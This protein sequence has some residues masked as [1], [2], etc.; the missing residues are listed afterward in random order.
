MARYNW[1]FNELREI[2]NEISK[3]YE[4]EN[5]KEEKEA[6][7]ETLNGYKRMLHIN[8]KEI[9]KI[10]S[11]SVEDIPIFYDDFIKKVASF[12]EDN[13]PEYIDLLTGTYPLIKKAYNEEMDVNY[14]IAFN[15]DSLIEIVLDFFSKMTPKEFYQKVKNLLEKNKDFLNITYSKNYNYKDNSTL[16]SKEY[17]KKFVLVT[18]HNDLLDFMGLPHEITHYLLNNYNY[19]DYLKTDSKFLTE[20]E[21]CLINLLIS[22]YYKNNSKTLFTDSY[23]KNNK[24][25][26]DSLFFKHKILGDIKEHIEHF[27]IK[28][29][30]LLSLDDDMKLIPERFCKRVKKFNLVDPSYDYLETLS[31]LASNETEELT[32]GFSYIAALDIYT[33]CLDDPEKAF[34]DLRNIK[35]RKRIKNLIPYLRENNIT[36]MDDNYKSLKK[37]IKNMTN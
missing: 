37:Y 26:D 6:L 9:P 16:F 28:N 33:E 14:K 12:Y 11:I 23:D 5:N 24:V 30:F 36:F 25:Y 2:Y 7:L 34:Y 10:E 27:I 17:K 31:Y 3:K 19:S 1:N 21:G 18:R 32:Y 13:K 20:I 35:K 8:R 22:E 29:E 15:N 4:K